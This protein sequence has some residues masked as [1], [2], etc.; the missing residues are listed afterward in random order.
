MWLEMTSMFRRKARG[1]RNGARLAILTVGIGALFLL[2][3]PAWASGP[4]V[5]YEA[6]FA[7]SFPLS[8]DEHAITDWTLYQALVTGDVVTYAL[9]VDPTIATEMD[10]IR[11]R[12]YQTQQ[13]E[14]RLK[15]DRRLI[16]AFDGQRKRLQSMVVATS[17]ADAKT[18]PRAVAYVENEFRLVLGESSEGG[19]PLSHATIAPSCPQTLDAG[20]QVTAGRS[21]RFTCWT[22][23]ESTLCGWRLPDMPVA[24]KRVIESDYPTKMTLRWRWRGLGAAVRTRYVDAGGNRVGPRA[25]ATLTVPLAL[26][27]E[28]VDGGGRVLWSAPPSASGGRRHAQVASGEK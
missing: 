26:G 21:S 7:K 23:K 22:G 14:N 18:C 25:S 11:G 17:G 27:V 28:F 3:R 8:G 1:L 9:R 13:L 2:C 10:G 4:A 12:A 19:D 5:D 20:F 24:L 16:A 6:V 15:Q